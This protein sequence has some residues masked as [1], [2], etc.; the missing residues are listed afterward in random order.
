MKRSTYI[1]IAIAMLAAMF[2]PQL[3]HG[4]TQM[5]LIT[6]RAGVINRS[7]DVSSSPILPA[8]NL[9]THITNILGPANTGSAA[10]IIQASSP[11][12]D[13]NHFL[14]SDNRLVVDVHNALSSLSGPFDGYGAVRGLRY[15]QFST[16]PNI[17]RVVF[18]LRH[19][20]EFS[21]A[22][23]YDRENIIVAFAVNDIFE[24]ESSSA[25]RSDA[26]VIRGDFQPSVRVSSDG[27]PHYFTVYI[28]NAQMSAHGMDMLGGALISGFS[29]GQNG[30]IAYMRVY[31]K[32]R[33][34]AISLAHGPDYV[35]VNLR[36][37]LYGVRYDFSDREVRLSKAAISMDISRVRVTE[38]YLRNRYVFILPSTDNDL[39]IGTLNVSDGY[40]ESVNLRVNT[41]GYTVVTIETSRVM[42]FRL[43]STDDYYIIRGHLPQEV[44]DFIV[45]IDPG[46]GGRDPGASHH[47]VVEKDLV[48]TIGHMVMEH[49]NQN[50]NIRAYMT[51]H[52]DVFVAN[53]WRAA[54]ANQFADLY[55][56]VHANAVNN[57]PRVQ[58]IE[59]WYRNSSRE[60]GL[61]FTSRQFAR[62]LQRRLINA[63]GAND[64]GTRTA[65]FVVL[66][67]T[68]MPAILLELGFLTNRE[69]AARLASSSHQRLLARTIYEGIVESFETF[70]PPR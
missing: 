2:I 16:A 33:W 52:T 45:V 5:R 63:T 18:D 17:T 26:L 3:V 49:I 39:G 34:P 24:I 60:N 47:G 43:H 8:P 59:T 55:V 30:D 29:T 57:L 31:V 38:E 58:G 28:D 62:I 21:I 41:A 7:V 11:I 67:D 53:T 12:T 56:S 15:S 50:P 4:V 22:L 19:Y 13:V 10:Y 37:G 1:F 48:L 70:T 51:R 54:F 42:A 69:E 27:Y 36:R 9:T 23:S 66:R 20:V 35:A 14:L 68:N 6:N 65:N 25:S 32:D 64:R 46:H 44:Y 61:G 40:I